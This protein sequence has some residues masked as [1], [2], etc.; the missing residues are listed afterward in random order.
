MEDQENRRVSNDPP[1]RLND[2]TEAIPPLS[3]NV[4]QFTFT[5]PLRPAPAMA[6]GSRA[7]VRQGDT[8]APASYAHAVQ[9]MPAISQVNRQPRPATPFPGPN[10]YL[11]TP[12]HDAYRPSNSSAPPARPPL[13]PIP[14][15]TIENIDELVLPQ[16]SL[17]YPNSRLSAR[18]SMEDPSMDLDLD[19]FDTPSR[20]PRHTSTPFVF[21]APLG[22]AGPATMPHARLF[23]ASLAAPATQP[24]RGPM[25]VGD[26]F[27]PQPRQPIF[28]PA[29]RPPTAQGIQNVTNGQQL[30]QSPGPFPANPNPAQPNQPMAGGIAPPNPPVAPPPQVNQQPPAPANA[31]ITFTATPAG[32][33]P[34]IHHDGPRGA[35]EG[36]S[37]ARLRVYEQAS[38]RTSVFF[39][40]YNSSRTPGQQSRSITA[41]LRPLITAATG[42]TDF[43]IIAPEPEIGWTPAQGPLPVTWLVINL[44]PEGALTLANQV[45]SSDAVTML[46]IRNPDEPTDYLMSVG[47]WSHNDNNDIEHTIRQIFHSPAVTP[48]IRALVAHN[49]RYQHL[50]PDVATQNILN[51]LRIVIHVL[52]NGNIIAT[53]YSTPPTADPDQWA[54]WINHARAVL[55]YSDTNTTGSARR[56]TRCAGC[57][58][59]DHPTHRCP[60]P[61]IPGWNGP[62]AAG[63]GLIA[64]PMAMNALPGLPAGNPFNAGPANA[65]IIAPAVNTQ[66]Q[67]GNQTRGRGRGRGNNNNRGNAGRGNRGGYRGF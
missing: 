46:P 47:G 30:P 28:V 9:A 37:A 48:A 15:P 66:N 62:A 21:Q 12:N 8:S 49:P 38:R 44:S 4:N 56:P 14:P 11:G 60:F 32:G 43:T 5:F 2:T 18:T 52:D 26:L 29:S 51:S 27:A 31:P 55:F 39:R 67:T 16:P 65:N 19:T 45:W 54:L 7:A 57:H 23:Q 42:E 34:T 58:S 53:I 22:A 10:D 61:T 36:L 59:I 35:F 33:W 1:R 41:Q 24:T 6:S 3:G 25:H 63:S 13:R 40:I 20:P 17:P 64:G 50:H